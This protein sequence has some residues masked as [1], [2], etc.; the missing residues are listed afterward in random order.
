MGPLQAPWSPPPSQFPSAGVRKLG[1]GVDTALLVNLLNEFDELRISRM[2]V[3]QKF[4]TDYTSD[5]ELFADLANILALLYAANKMVHMPRG[6][7]SD[8][9]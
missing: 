2:H 9:Q 3:A 4:L 6:F 1:D 8:T 7:K 5:D